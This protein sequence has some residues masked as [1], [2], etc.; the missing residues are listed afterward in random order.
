MDTQLIKDRA[1]V[2]QIM[3]GLLGIT[4]LIVGQDGVLVGAIAG[5]LINLGGFFNARK[6]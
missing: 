3:L 4:A 1:I 5:G 2:A 6:E